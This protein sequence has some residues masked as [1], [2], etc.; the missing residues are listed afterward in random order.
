MCTLQDPNQSLTP[1]Q[2]SCQRP[3]EVLWGFAG[4]HPVDEPCKH[5]D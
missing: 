1:H 3:P 4:V 2:Q 5:A